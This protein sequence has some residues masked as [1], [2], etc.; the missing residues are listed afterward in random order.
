MNISIAPL[1]PDATKRQIWM[2]N[3][4][5]PLAIPFLVVAVGTGIAIGVSQSIDASEQQRHDFRETTY[6]GARYGHCEE[7]AKTLDK[8]GT[9]IVSA[10]VCELIGKAEMEDRNLPTQVKLWIGSNPNEEWYDHC[11]AAAEPESGKAPP[12]VIRCLLNPHR[13]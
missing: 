10:V 8:D 11:T 9:V 13:N 2:R 5:W 3:H 4:F 6:Q 7:S 12:S 1:P